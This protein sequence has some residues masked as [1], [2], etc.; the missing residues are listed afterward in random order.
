VRVCNVYVWCYHRFILVY[1][2]LLKCLSCN[3]S[4]LQG[5]TPFI[6]LYLYNVIY[7][8]FLVCNVL[9]ACRLC[10]RCIIIIIILLINMY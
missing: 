4:L 1:K 8:Y 9:C 3:V 2:L 6:S 5:G 7:C 10:L